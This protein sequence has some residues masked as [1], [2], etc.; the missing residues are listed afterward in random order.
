MSDKK[1]EISVNDILQA[2]DVLISIMLSKILTISKN[3]AQTVAQMKELVNMQEINPNA[4]EHINLLFV[5]SSACAKSALLQTNTLT[6]FL[7]DLLN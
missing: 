4:K 7:P 3:P 5:C 1:I 6:F 2:H